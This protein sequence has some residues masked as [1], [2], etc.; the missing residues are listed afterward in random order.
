MLTTSPASQTPS[1]DIKVT[2][3]YISLGRAMGRG[4]SLFDGAAYFGGTYTISTTNDS[5][6]TN[7]TKIASDGVKTVGSTAN[8][9][10][11][12][13]PDN[14]MFNTAS[15]IFQIKNDGSFVFNCGAYTYVLPV[16]RSTL[17][18]LALQPKYTSYSPTT[19]TATTQYYFFI[20]GTGSSP[21]NMRYFYRSEDNNIVV[22]N[23]SSALSLTNC[24]WAGKGGIC[25]EGHVVN[26]QA[27][28]QS[29]RIQ[30]STSTT[31]ANPVSV[32]TITMPPMSVAKFFLY[33]PTSTQSSGYCVVF[34]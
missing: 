2:P 25:G 5:S 21:T 12:L 8:T 33:R 1:N 26:T 22:G 19:S 15:T 29:V 3:N 32:M 9:F 4:L 23:L 18:V 28:V 11:R 27:A 10:S 20:S 14:I 31:G 34:G 13:S 16:S 7:I 17:N 24:L 30:Q 6:F